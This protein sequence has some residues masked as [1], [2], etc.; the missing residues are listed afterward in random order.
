MATY[1]D[2]EDDTVSFQ[3]LLEDDIESPQDL[4]EDDTVS[5]QALLDALED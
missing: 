1:T 4:P 5:F 3:A 2:P